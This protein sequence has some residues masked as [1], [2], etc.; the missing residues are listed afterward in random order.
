MFNGTL[1][2]AFWSPME[3]SRSDWNH[4]FSTHFHS[5]MRG[6]FK[7]FYWPTYCQTILATIYLTSR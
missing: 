3:T 7:I 5:I 1:F 2:L 6:L 4:G